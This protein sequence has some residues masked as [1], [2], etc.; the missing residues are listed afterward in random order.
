MWIPIKNFE[1]L[2]SINEKGEVLS[3]SRKVTLYN[4]GWYTT[5]ERILKPYLTKKGYAAVDLGSARFVVHRLV[6]QAFLPNPENKPQV[7]HIDGDKINNHVSNLEWV[8]NQENVQHAHDIGLIQMTEK[9]LQRLRDQNEKLKKK[10]AQYTLNGELINIYE[11]VRYVHN[12][13]DYK[14]SSVSKAC[15][16]DLKTYKGFIWK[17]VE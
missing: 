13:T 4:G 6:A 5:N 11:S 8:T 7:N 3:H 12:N 14:Q 16:G 2:Y 1:G 10:V 9:K 15:R 17:Y